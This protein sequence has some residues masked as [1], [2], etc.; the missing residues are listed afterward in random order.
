MLNVRCS[1]WDFG[2]GYIEFRVSIGQ[3]I[4]TCEGFCAF[5]FFLY[6][7]LCRF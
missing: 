6:G 3:C 2:L 5:E 1:V 4:V 7:V